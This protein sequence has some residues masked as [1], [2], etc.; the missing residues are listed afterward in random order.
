MRLDPAGHSRTVARQYDGLAPKYESR[1]HFYVEATADET[2]GRLTI[3]P[4]DHLL[5]IACGTGCLLEKIKAQQPRAHLAGIDLSFQMLRIARRRGPRLRLVRADAL[6]LPFPD[7]T[8]DAVVC[9]NSFHFISDPKAALAEMRR[10]LKPG[11]ALLLTD[12]CDDYIW[13]RLCDWYLR[14][15][16]AAH[17]RM[18]G[19][20]QCRELLAEN[21]FRVERLD[22]YRVSWLWG[23][24]TLIARPG[25]DPARSMEPGRSAWSD[26]RD[27]NDPRDPRM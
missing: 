20:R 8:F 13:C 24:M 17:V 3:G 14:L 5:E 21:G 1:W 23:L 9:S 25:P 27:P 6:S 26:P 19:S 18:Y 22:R 15:T 11:A 10:V 2:L 4:G 16:D 7:R 12:W